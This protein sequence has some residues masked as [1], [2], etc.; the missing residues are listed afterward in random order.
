MPITQ[1]LPKKNSQ[2]TPGGLVLCACTC[3]SILSFTFN[4]GGASL[5][6]PVS[7]RLKKVYDHATQHGHTQANIKIPIIKGC[8]SF[9]NRVQ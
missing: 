6:S 5:C 7:N 2:K 8:L 4:I 3:N 9:Q 1:Y